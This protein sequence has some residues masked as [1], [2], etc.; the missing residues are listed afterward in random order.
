MMAEGYTESVPEASGCRY[1]ERCMT[2]Y[3]WRNACRYTGKA[4]A[5]SGTLARA[6]SLSAPASQSSGEPSEDA[7]R[8]TVELPSPRRGQACLHPR[9]ATKAGASAE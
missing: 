8:G 3:A 1:R 5:G 4:P 7:S 6:R 2:T 9:V